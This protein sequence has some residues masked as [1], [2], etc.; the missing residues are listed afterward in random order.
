MIRDLKLEVQKLE[1]QIQLLNK[2]SGATSAVE[3][4]KD[5]A[6]VSVSCPVRQQVNEVMEINKR[7][8]KVIISE[9]REDGGCHRLELII[10]CLSWVT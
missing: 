1:E 2:K 4:E 5:A 3:M 9:I 7:K 6:L 10:F 8:D